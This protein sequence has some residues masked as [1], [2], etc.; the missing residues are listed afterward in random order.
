MVIELMNSL[1]NRGAI[2]IILAFLLSKSSL[3]KKLVLKKDITYLEKIAMGILFGIFGIIGTYSGIPV[4]GAIAN[5]R[6]IGVFVGGW[7]GGPVVGILSGVIAG[8]HRWAI[9]I[10]GFTAVACAV[11]TIVE[12]AI[13][14]YGSRLVKDLKTSWLG[15]LVLGAAAEIIQMIIILVVAKPFP[16]ALNLV[17]L[18]WFPMVFVNSI[19]IS[20]FIAMTQNIFIEHERI[21]AAQAHLALKIANETL[22]V[23]RKGFHMDSI[24]RTAEIIYEMTNVA[25]VAITDT[26]H[27]LAHIGEASDHHLTGSPILTQITKDVIDSG[28]YRVA[29]TPAEIDCNEKECK[30]LSAVIVP[31]FDRDRVAGTLKLYK[32]DKLG[33]TSTDIQ[34]ALGL[35]QLFSTQIELSKLE[36]QNKLLAKA[37]LRALQAQI[38]PH[39]LFNALNTI[40]S[41]IRTKP[42]EAR[43]LIIHLSD[44][45]RQSLQFNSG[46]I[47]LMREIKNI[48][49][50]LA[51]ERARFGEKLKIIYEIPE[52]IVCV[53]PPLILQPVVENA[54]KHGIF[55]KAEGGTVII[56]AIDKKEYVELIVEDDGIGM[57]QDKLQGLLKE[58]RN[59][60]HIG[61]MNVNKRLKTKYGAE[62]CLSIASQVGLGTTVKMVIPKD[63]Y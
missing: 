21:G 34:L 23:L 63:K 54:V 5:S 48:E 17:E 15:A 37:E 36:Y 2:I 41:F 28:A 30:L 27:I 19:G 50:Y 9:D 29:R 33:I 51:L 18:I 52:N 59:T 31:L 24:K 20:I 56:R 44:Y 16:D 42:E 4:K 11:S 7:L 46:D 62:Y 55:N 45:F 12:G 38:N 8:G 58:E 1:M 6:V 26:E 35:A 53:I 13:S 40:A 3:F 60:N 10:G 61:L 39:F 49:S 25:A 14:G 32:S 57:D 47:D 43:E 22:P